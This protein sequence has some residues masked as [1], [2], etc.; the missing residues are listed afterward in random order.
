MNKIK[1]CLFIVYCLSLITFS[2]CS[3]NPLASSGTIGFGAEAKSITSAPAYRGGPSL[4]SSP[5]EFEVTVEKIEISETGDKWIEVHNNSKSTV[6]TGTDVGTIVGAIP[7]DTAEYEG[8]KVWFGKTLK[9]TDSH[10]SITEWNDFDR[11]NPVIFSTKNGKLSY[12]F[13]VERSNV[14]AIIFQFNF[15]SSNSAPALVIMGGFLRPSVI[16]RVSKFK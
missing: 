7:V 6:V 14:C 3:K 2:S 12:P 9:A 10:G 11:D 8:I 16:A 15:N 1:Y 4:I 13:S 5:S